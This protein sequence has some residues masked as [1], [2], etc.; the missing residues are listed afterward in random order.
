MNLKQRVS[1]NPNDPNEYEDTYLERKA[2]RTDRFWRYT[3]G[4]K[5]RRCSACNGSGYYDHNGSPPCSSCS[6]SAREKFRG[7]KSLAMDG[8]QP[9]AKKQ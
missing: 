8:P 2:H 3:Y 7:P 4:W 5:E 9:R 1:R 6:G